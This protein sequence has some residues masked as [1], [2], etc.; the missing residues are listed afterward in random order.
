MFAMYLGYQ[1]NTSRVQQSMIW[2]GGY[3]TKFIKKN[4]RGYR[5]LSTDKIHAMITHLPITSTYYWQVSL[6]G[7]HVGRKS[8]SGLTVNQI[9]FDTGSSL[10]YAPLRDFQ[11]LMNLITAGKR[12]STMNGQYFCRCRKNSF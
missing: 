10:N 2:F 8:I 9:I 1:D 7:V 11:K 12:C 4:F 6:Q 5:N 3:S